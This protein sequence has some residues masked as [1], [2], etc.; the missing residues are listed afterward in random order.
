MSNRKGRATVS[1]VGSTGA[2][3]DDPSNIVCQSC[4]N[5]PTTVAIQITVFDQNDTITKY[6]PN[7]TYQIHVKVNYVSGTVPK[8]H[9]FQMTLLNAAKNKSGT[10]LKALKAISPNVQLVTPRNGRLYAEQLDRSITNL[11]EVEWTAPAIGSGPIT[12]YAAGTGVNSN[13]SDSGDGGSRSALQLDEKVISG[14]NDIANSQ[15]AIYPNPFIDKFYIQDAQDLI[16]KLELTDLFG[17]RIKYLSI[18][19]NNT[20]DLTDVNDGIYFAKLLNSKDQL[21]K[22]LKLLKRS[23]TP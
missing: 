9:G 21:I 20:V 1:N 16:K 2:P 15:I 5:G 22:T 10:N 8:A 3:G 13:D 4:H 11:F 14:S 6:E 19:D 23:Q 18:N 12:I 7:K 17:R